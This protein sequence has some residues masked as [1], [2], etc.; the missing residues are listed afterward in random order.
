[1]TSSFRTAVSAELLKCRRSRIPLVTAAVVIFAA[2]IGIMFMLILRNP[3]GSQ[4]FGVL[5][6]K[7]QMSGLSADW[8]SLLTF[9]TQVVAV[10]GSMIFA[11]V[12]IWVFG[13]EFSD[14]TARYLLALPVPRRSIVLAKFV[15]I[16]AWCLALTALMLLVTAGLGF[17]IGLAGASPE[18]LVAGSARSLLAAVLI[19]LAIC[20]L[21]Y[22]A[23]RARGY[24]AALASALILLVIAQIAA[25]LQLGEY[26]P[27]SIPA[28]AAGLVPGAQF[29]AL[30]LLIEVAT[31]LIGAAVTFKW[32][33]GGDVGL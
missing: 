3:G 22:V 32:W 24:L 13:R 15:I 5:A 29:G 26:F 21:A 7:A 18:I 19:I 28:V 8:T 16:F 17:A 30:P 23:S 11:F 1:M 6:Q 20:P 9:I 25:A 31:G 4:Q 14:G 10:G 2:G 12:A 33:L 27:W